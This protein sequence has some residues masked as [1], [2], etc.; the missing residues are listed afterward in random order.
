MLQIRE[1]TA[2]DAH[3]IARF[4]QSM[5][6]ETEQHHLDETSL[7]SGVRAVLEDSAKGR[8]FVAEGG[9]QVVGCLMITR[10]FSDW[11]DGWFWWIQS[12]YVVEAWRRN[13]V[14]R[15][16]YRFVQQLASQT[17]GVLGLR[18]YVDHD[19]HKAQRTYEAMGMQRARYAMFE[20]RTVP[21]GTE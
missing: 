6:W 12:V 14:F 1:A 13:G 17:P 11:R 5:A 20:S 16:L 10:E 9:G 7:S 18:L 21:S 3:V 15:S 19:N 8:Y 4:Q 2:A